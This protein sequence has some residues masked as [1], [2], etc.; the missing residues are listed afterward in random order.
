MVTL[1]SQ[2][3]SGDTPIV[4]TGLEFVYC[5]EGCITYEV[6][7][8]TFTLDSGTA[9]YSMPITTPLAQCRKYALPF[10]T[11]TLPL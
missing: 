6:E 7:G 8:E 10:I 4:H 3:D 2:A 11:P 5:L 1:E 9:F